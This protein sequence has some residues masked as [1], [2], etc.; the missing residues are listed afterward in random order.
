MAR[1]PRQRTQGMEPVASVPFE[2]RK[3]LE[4]GFKRHYEDVEP[5]GINGPQSPDSQNAG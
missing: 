5:S 4:M 2:N 3:G 1:S